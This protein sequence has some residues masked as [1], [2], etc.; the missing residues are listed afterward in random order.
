MD[1]W[2]KRFEQKLDW[3]LE[4]IHSIDKTLAEQALQIKIH[5]KGT[6]INAKALTA[7]E[8]KIAAD[9]TPIKDHVNGM[10][11]LL[12]TVGVFSLLL[13]LA[14]TALKTYEWFAARPTSGIKSNAQV[15]NLRITRPEKPGN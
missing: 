4:R 13:T 12:K 15:P 10:N 5:I 3:N 11:Y 14:F 2:Q 6:R 1:D 8:R 7:L 9:I